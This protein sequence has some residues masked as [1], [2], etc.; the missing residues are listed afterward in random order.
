MSP[1]LFGAA[2]Y[3]EYQPRPR[4][5]ED[6]DLMA[7]AGF[8][9]I[10]VGESVWATWEPR[11][12]ELDLEWITP[13]LDGAHERGIAVILGTP[14]Y[15]VPPWLRRRYPETTAQRRTG[16][17]I[18]YGHRQNVDYGHPTF[19]RLA[20][21]LVRAIVE[22]HA[23][24]P[25][26]IGYQVDNEPG[27]ELLHNPEAFAGFVAYLRERHRSVEAL[28]A[29]WG[30]TYWSQRLAGFDELWPP[31]GNTSPG[32]DL[33]WR[34]FQAARTSDF[35]RWQ[36][37]IVRELARPDQFVTTCLAYGRPAADIA[38]L[39]R[40]LDVAAVNPY[41]AMQDA[42]AL[43]QPPAPAQ[44]GWP[45]WS[46]GGGVR[47][48][49]LMA[50]IAHG[51]KRAP[52]LV[53]ETH[54]SSIG[55]SHVN[56]PPYDGQLRQAAWALIARGARMVAYWHWHTLHY[57]NETYWGGVLGH[58]LEPGR[59][60]AEVARIGAELRAAG[61]SL[62]GMEPDADAALV[63]SADSRWALAFQPP[64]ARGD[65]SPDRGC[66]D[67]ILATFHRGLLDAGAQAAVVA[68]GSLGG[69]PAALAARWPVLIAPALYV[70]SDELLRLL[71]GYARAGGHLVL[72][73]R[74]GCADEHGALRPHVMP[75]ALRE[76]VGA[77]YTEFSNLAAPVPLEGLPLGAG[78]ATEWADGL[79]PEGAAPLA[80]YRHRHLHRW[81]AITTNA[82][83]AGR[84]TYVG[85]LPDPE[86]A[87]A[88]AGW[89][90]PEPSARGGWGPCPAS[91][92]L[93]GAC[94]EDG[95]RLRFASNWSWEPA[96]LTPAA[97]VRDLLSGAVLAAG[98]RLELGAWDVRVLIE[99]RR[100][101]RQT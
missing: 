81:P 35:I 10:R 38:D 11:E 65:G 23:G 14:T 56:F 66:Y 4:L 54:A 50:D 75:G 58:G 79:E 92:T 85:T 30:L 59:V 80:R 68:A 36:A 2:Y 98:E 26:V 71:A 13:V 27:V 69:D 100:E 9:V 60:F 63:H 94:T 19:R 8:S 86:L 25:A 1:V 41:Y 29:R 78:R 91:V 5:D 22:R 70:A 73:F 74:S 52:F 3:H 62:D 20:E 90:V 21:R 40:D 46:D 15:A 83:G 7:R 48:L 17:P 24:H 34:R 57:G 89:L 32:Y 51:L 18:P 16:E 12:G 45:E 49:Y 53:T 82:H 76:A 88:L 61:A 67:R 55:E 39:A 44:A 77:S 95:R 33:A 101:D 87:A 42:F 31:D 64:L 28:N 97:E 6:L 84:V 43:P 96:S 47:S 99:P 93:T 72:G 37:A